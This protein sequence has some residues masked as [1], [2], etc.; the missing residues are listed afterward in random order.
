MLVL[1]STFK[2][3]I[4]RKVKPFFISNNAFLVKLSGYNGD[5]TFGS[6]IETNLKIG[7]VWYIVDW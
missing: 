5:V 4:L 2:L 7:F 1:L 3:H 6:K